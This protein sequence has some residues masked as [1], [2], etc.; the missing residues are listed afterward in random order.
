MSDDDAAN[1]MQDA[2]IEELEAEF[3]RPENFIGFPPPGLEPPPINTMN[4]SP[5]A[6]AHTGAGHTH[7]SLFPSSMP[8]RATFQAGDAL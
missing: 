3:N 5:G 2:R 6:M 4:V 8:V 1:Q 7:T